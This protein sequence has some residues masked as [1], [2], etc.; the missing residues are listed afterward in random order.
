M[1]KEKMSIDQKAILNQIDSLL[2][3]YNDLR[4]KSQHSDLSGLPR[5]DVTALVTRIVAAIE[6]LSPPGSR[7]IENVRQHNQ[8]RGGNAGHILPSIVGIMK[9]LRADYEAGHLQ[10]VTELIHADIFG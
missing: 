8:S 10:S 3:E 9:A 1:G 2:S 5:E 4:P 7:Y 6:R